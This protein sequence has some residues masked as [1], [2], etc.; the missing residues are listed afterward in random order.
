VQEV[1]A[2]LYHNLGMDINRVTIP[3]LSGQPRFL[4]DDNRQPISELL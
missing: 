1:F 4:V 2:T 3:D